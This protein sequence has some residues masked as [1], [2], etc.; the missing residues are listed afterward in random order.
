MIPGSSSTATSS[1]DGRIAAGYP[2]GV[3]TDA[4][5]WGSYPAA[6]SARCFGLVQELPVGIAERSRRL[7]AWGSCVRLEASGG[8]SG[9][10]SEGPSV[11]PGDRARSNPP[12]IL[13]R[14]APAA[15]LSYGTVRLYSCTGYS[16]FCARDRTRGCFA[17][18]LLQ[19]GTKLLA[20]R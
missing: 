14:P 11:R 6:A 19:L 18:L 12:R 8:R 1:D 17:C 5:A 15:I 2:T 16:R 9:R 13:H 4:R 7:C 20:R 3:L 10:R